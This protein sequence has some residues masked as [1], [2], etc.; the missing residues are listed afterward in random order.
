MYFVLANSTMALYAND[1]KM[2]RLINCDNDQMLFQDT[3]GELYHW[4]Q[5]NLSGGFQLQKAQ[6]HELLKKSPLSQQTAFE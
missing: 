5:R 2:F 1:S 6:H 3:L 4:S